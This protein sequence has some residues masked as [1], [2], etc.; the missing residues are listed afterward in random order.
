MKALP[1]IL[2]VSTLFALQAAGYAQQ[3]ALPMPKG[4]MDMLP[5]PNSP[6]QKGK[7]AVIKYALIM[8]DDK[9]AER[10]KDSERNPFGR[11][12]EEKKGITVKASNEENV[13]REQLLKL[14]V[15]GASPDERGMRVMLGDMI[16][17]KDQLVPPILTEQTI[18]LKVGKITREAIE[19]VW[20]E[21]KDSGL[22]P[23][24]LVIPMDLTP[25]V[26]YQ[27]QGQQP[28]DLIAKK[29]AATEAQGRK[30]GLQ[31]QPGLTQV[32]KDPPKKASVAATSYD[33]VP[34]A[35]AVAETEQQT[36]KLGQIPA[37]KTATAVGDQP[38]TPT[39]ATAQANGQPSAQS[40][41]ATADPAHPAGTGPEALAPLK[42]AFELFNALTKPVSDKQ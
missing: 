11:N 22:P 42:K 26:R 33:T 12:D 14:R 13:I 1:T 29:A 32:A 31:V 38:A 7:G 4:P 34:A 3:P 39:Q 2:F 16:L 10:V 5:D 6:T 40:G 20:V 17:T 18:F 8:P 35:T 30:M 24:K 15:V 36:A 41:P 23:R 9:T 27:L 25:K 28:A 19:L 37:E 21:K